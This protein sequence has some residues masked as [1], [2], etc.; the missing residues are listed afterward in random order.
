[1]SR[2]DA[3]LLEARLGSGVDGLTARKVADVSC[4]VDPKRFEAGCTTCGRVEKTPEPRCTTCSRGSR[5]SNPLRTM[6]GRAFRRFRSTAHDVQGRSRALLSTLHD[7]RRCQKVSDPR[8]TTR[9]RAL[10]P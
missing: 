1:R 8:C 4:N 5:R 9:R 10:G 2:P 3:T 6:L 7:V